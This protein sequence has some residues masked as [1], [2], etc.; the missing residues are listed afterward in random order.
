M[1]L[2]GARANPTT[3]TTTTTPITSTT[4]TPTAVTAPITPRKKLVRWIVCGPGKIYGFM[5]I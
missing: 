1:K 4:T 2:K 3:A 5:Y